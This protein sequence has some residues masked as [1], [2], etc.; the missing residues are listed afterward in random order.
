MSERKY[1]PCGVI[2]L[3]MIVC[4]VA[5]IAVAWPIPPHLFMKGY[6]AGYGEGYKQGD[7]VAR[8]DCKP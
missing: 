4:V 8:L 6:E 7:L 2:S 3:C 5:L 1:L